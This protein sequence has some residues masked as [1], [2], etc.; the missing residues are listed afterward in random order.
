MAPQRDAEICLKV[1]LMCGS[2]QHMDIKQH[3]QHWFPSSDP[4]G[5][6]VLTSHW[7]H[8]ILLDFSEAYADLDCDGALRRGPQLTGTV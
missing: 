3:I 1:A 8:H 6:Q 5:S 4:L 2:S 7:S